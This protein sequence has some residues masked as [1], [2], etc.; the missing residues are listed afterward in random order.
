GE[1]RECVLDGAAVSAD[2]AALAELDAAVVARH[3]CRDLANTGMQQH[4]EHRPAGGAVRLAGIAEAYVRGAAGRTGQERPAVVG[5]VGEPGAH[6]VNARTCG[7]DGGRVRERGDEPAALDGLL[8]A[9]RRRGNRVTARGHCAAA[10]PAPTARSRS[11][12]TSAFVS[13]RPNASAP[14]PPANG[15]TIVAVWPGVV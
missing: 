3:D 10:A 12:P 7:I 1:R 9:V 15:G 6:V 14:G 4:V 5:R 8:G 11:R 2:E 13:Q